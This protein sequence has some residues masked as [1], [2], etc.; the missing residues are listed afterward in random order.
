MP[1]IGLGLGL[2]CW[3]GWVNVD[4]PKEIYYLVDENG[5]FILDENGNKIIVV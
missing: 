3:P 2:D 4:K 1:R 5:N